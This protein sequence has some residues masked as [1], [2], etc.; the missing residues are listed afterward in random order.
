MKDDDLIAG[1]R[2]HQQV[3]GAKGACDFIK[4]DGI[5]TRSNNPKGRPK[6]KGGRSKCIQKKVCKSCGIEKEIKSFG[7]AGGNSYNK[8]DNCLVCSPSEDYSF[9]SSKKFKDKKD[10]VE[11]KEAYIPDVNVLTR[12]VLYH[13]DK[14]QVD[15][16]YEE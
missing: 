14:E 2:K 12:S 10:Y 8:K 5:Y 11:I 6:K 7:K 15:V 16:N 9:G 4:A 1:L 3:M 13:S